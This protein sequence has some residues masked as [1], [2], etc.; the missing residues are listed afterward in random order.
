MTTNKI[1]KYL[2]NDIK[3]KRDWA[4]ENNIHKPEIE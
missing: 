1:Q 3:R 4:N 2:P